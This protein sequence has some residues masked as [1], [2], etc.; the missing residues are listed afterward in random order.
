MVAVEALSPTE[1]RVAFRVGDSH[2]EARS[3]SLRGGARLEVTRCRF[4]PSFSFAAQQRPAEIELS[5]SKGALLRTRTRDGVDL[6]RGGNVLQ[7]G[8]TR[9]PVTVDVR[10]EGDAPMTCVAIA[11]SEARLR[12]LLGVRALPA[13]LRQVTESRDPYPLLSRAPTAALLGLLDEITHADV[14]GPSRLLW[15]EAKG[16]ELVARMTDAFIEIDESRVAIA[17]VERLERARTTL[18]AHLQAPPTL[19]QLARA[20]GFS[21]TKLKTLFRAHFGTSI[22][23]YLRRARMEEA[24]RLLLARAANVSEAAQRV[25]YLNPSKFA[26]AFRRQFGVSPSSL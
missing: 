5:V 13:S 7:L 23:A 8:K 9:R 2:C 3:F 22:F 20:A 16:L 4:V 6:D 15:H 10:Q 17:D 1:Q 11:M 18:L 21:D 26:A 24:R 19:A 14:R 12:E 25:G